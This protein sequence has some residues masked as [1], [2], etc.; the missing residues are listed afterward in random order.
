MIF[1]TERLILSEFTKE[2]VPFIL[3]LT[4]S[5][6]WLKYIGDRGIRTEADAEEYIEKSLL[7]S[8]RKNGFGLYKVTLK[9]SG[10]TIGMCGLVKRD[11]LEQVDIGFGFLKQYFGK[12]YAYESAKETLIYAKEKLNI[13]SIVAITNPD[14]K[15]SIRL[16]EKL[17]MKFKEMISLTGGEPDT[18][19][20]V[21]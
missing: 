4:N 17:G 15:P 1:E 3:E 20:F 6:G 21:F 14:N 18:N 16:L 10:E 13:E 19:L 5:E 8:Y 11:G 7:G 12:G 2:D 9:K